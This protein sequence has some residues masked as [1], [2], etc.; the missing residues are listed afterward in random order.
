MNESL[1]RL[2]R[3]CMPK[4]Y[5]LERNHVMSPIE[6]AFVGEEGKELCVMMNDE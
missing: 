1:Q 2:P 4:D 6:S 5:D 3:G